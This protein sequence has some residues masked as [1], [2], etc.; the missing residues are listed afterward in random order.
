MDDFERFKGSM[1]K[2]TA[3]V[4][5]IAR[6]PELEPEDV[7]E[8]LHSQDQTWTDELLL[9]DEQR[10]WFLETES[11]GEDTVKVVEMTIK[12]LDYYI[13]VVAGFERIDSSFERG[14][15][16][17]KSCATEKLWKEGSVWQTSLLSCCWPQPAHLHQPPPWLVISHQHQ[18]KTHHQQDYDWPKAQMMASIF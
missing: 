7:T 2:V 14:S 5:E 16:L 15:I 12:D 6:Q 18:G 11:I 8:S 1:G 4:V 13:N 9:T 10:K 17:S 3:N